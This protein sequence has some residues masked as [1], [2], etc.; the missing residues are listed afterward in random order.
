LG[1]AL[2]RRGRHLAIAHGSDLRLLGQ[3]P[4]GASL[5]RGI[6]RH[7][8]LVYVARAL[9]VVGA[10]GRV[11]PMGIDL[12]S[13]T[14]RPGEREAMRQAHGLDRF[15]YLVLGRLSKE[16]GVDRA[17]AAVPPRAALI[18]AGAG[19]ERPALEAL[20]RRRRPAGRVRFVDE[21]RGDEK[22]RWL[23]AA[24]ALVVPSRHEGAPTV[25]FEAKAAG[26]PVV[27]TRAGGL[28]EVVDHGVDG[29]LCEPADL[30]AA[31]EHVSAD[32]ALCSRLAGG[33]RLAA[34]AHDWRAVG[35]QLWGDRLGSAL[36]ATTQCARVIAVH[37]V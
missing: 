3:L 17:I 2:A 22:R 7:A 10:P 6:A 15:T 5:V 31:L 24:D 14:P 11:V 12:D 36:P 35:P 33:A 20:V 37:R 32:G 19:P 4:F 34:K 28:A 9:G 25:V 26:L 13:V 18:V 23:A 16:K 8:D 27:A 1:L 30:A 21:V 29:W